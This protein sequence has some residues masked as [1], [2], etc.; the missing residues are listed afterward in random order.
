MFIESVDSRFGPARTQDELSEA[1]FPTGR[2]GEEPDD[3]IPCL[4][5][6]QRHDEVSE[7]AC[8]IGGVGKDPVTSYTE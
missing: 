5:V 6:F 4:D 3:I 2:G 8:P 1:P 7:T